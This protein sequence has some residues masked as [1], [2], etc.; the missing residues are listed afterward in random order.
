MQ[1]DYSKNK[2]ICMQNVEWRHLLSTNP[3]LRTY[4]KFKEN[5]V[6]KIMLNTALLEEKDH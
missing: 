2:Y 4:V 6:L 3:K 5:N 1:S